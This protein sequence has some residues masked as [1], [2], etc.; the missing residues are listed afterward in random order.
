MFESAEPFLD[1][2]QTWSVSFQTSNDDRLRFF[3]A[4]VVDRLR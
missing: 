2:P 4:F 3:A 1:E